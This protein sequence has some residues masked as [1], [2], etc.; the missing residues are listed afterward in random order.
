[1]P[2]PFPGIDPYLEMSGD[3]PDFHLRFIAHCAEL[4]ADRLPR[5]YRARAQ[6]Q[7][8]LVYAPG[9]EIRTATPDA[10]ISQVRP[11]ADATAPS[12]G[13]VATLEPVTI[14]YAATMEVRE[15]WIEIV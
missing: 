1:M 10:A 5:R 4:L 9:G 6:E 8:R 3:W 7:I 15:T 14:P 2:N 12:A 11:G 13:A